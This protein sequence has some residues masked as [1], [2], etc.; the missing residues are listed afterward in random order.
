MDIGSIAK[1][2][3]EGV[4]MMFGKKSGPV[5]SRS[6]F[7]D[8][9]DYQSTG[10]FRAANALSPADYY[11]GWGHT[12]ISTIANHVSILEKVLE[13]EKGDPIKNNPLFDMLHFEFLRDL[14]SFLEIYGRGYVWKN[15]MPGTKK[16]VSIEVLNPAGVEV[17]RWPAS[18]GRIGVQRYE[19]K[20]GGSKWTIQPENMIVFT[21]FHPAQAY[22]YNQD[23]G[24]SGLAASDFV[25]DADKKSDIWNGKIFD[26]S[27]YAGNVLQTEQSLTPEVTKRIADKWDQDHKDIRNAHKTAVL[28]HGLKQAEGKN[29]KD[30]DFSKLKE[31]ARDVILGRL[32]VPK[33]VM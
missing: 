4:G 21:Y 3:A 6:D 7:F 28:T 18:S 16:I 20:S 23:R 26:N 5:M 10:F 9:D 32:K 1:N 31:V 19:Y 29:Q 13:N 22:P 30:M 24:M 2:I 11:T 15:I 25:I 12:G 27:G 17:I 14:V 33:S 8:A